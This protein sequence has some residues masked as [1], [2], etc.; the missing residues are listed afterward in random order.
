MQIACQ[1]G[2]VVVLQRNERIKKGG[3]LP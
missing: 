1:V 2:S 3:A